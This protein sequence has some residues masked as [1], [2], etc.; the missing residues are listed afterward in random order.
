MARFT[1]VSEG[2]GPAGAS[3][4][5]DYTLDLGNGHVVTRHDSERR[6]AG[7]RKGRAASVE[8]YRRFECTCGGKLNDYGN[9]I[10]RSLAELRHFENDAERQAHEQHEAELRERILRATEDR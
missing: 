10:A 5:S 9:T 4:E 3:W 8:V 6:M 7:G 1:K 2:P